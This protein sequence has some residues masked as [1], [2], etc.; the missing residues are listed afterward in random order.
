[1]KEISDHNIDKYEIRE[2]KKGLITTKLRKL[3]VE[4]KDGTKYWIPLE[5]LKE[6]NP[7][8]TSE[9]ADSNKLLEEPAFK[10]WANKVL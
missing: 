5:D 3:L 4:W 9:Y 10:W 8:E 2:R 7:V 6:Y 1:M